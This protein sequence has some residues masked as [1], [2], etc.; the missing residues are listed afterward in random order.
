MTEENDLPLKVR[1][2]AIELEEN[3]GGD[4]M[5]KDYVY[6]VLLGVVFPGLLLIWGWY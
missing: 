5:L 6:Y 3:Q 4:L 2:E 1:L